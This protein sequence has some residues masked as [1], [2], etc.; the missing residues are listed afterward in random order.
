MLTEKFDSKEVCRRFGSGLEVVCVEGLY[1]AQSASLPE[2]DLVVTFHPGFPTVSRRSWDSVLLNVLD[3]GIPLMVVDMVEALDK[4]E[5]FAGAQTWNTIFKQGSTTGIAV[6]AGDTWVA[7]HG[8]EDED[9]AITLNHYGARSLGMWRNPFPVLL[10]QGSGLES[11]NKSMKVE[12]AAKSIVVQA[13]RGRVGGRKPESAPKLTKDEET[14]LR[15][16]KW[17]KIKDGY[18]MKEWLKIPVSNAFARA[19]RDVHIARILKT[20]ELLQKESL[21]AEVLQRAETLGFKEGSTRKGHVD[22]HDPG[23]TVD[24]W[25]FLFR[26][27][28]L[29][30]KYHF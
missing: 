4:E 26:D 12:T 1:Q 24:D 2:P 9:S 23:W 25:I 16:T 27:V 28:K 3:K 20:P 10:G 29:A 21:D 5:D 13:Y 17:A 15:R 7:Q 14:V 22:E 30:D 8:F 6:A 18:E 11:H 19:S